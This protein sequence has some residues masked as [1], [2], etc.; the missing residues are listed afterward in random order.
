MH[1]DTDFEEPAPR[2]AYPEGLRLARWLT[3]SIG[4]HQMRKATLMLGFYQDGYWLRRFTQDP[5]LAGTVAP[6][7]PQAW[8]LG[9]GMSL[10]PPRTSPEPAR[11]DRLAPDGR[12]P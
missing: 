9:G 11:L 2:P 5:A 12:P 7:D 10:A 8:D 3:D 1:L 6:A 4:N